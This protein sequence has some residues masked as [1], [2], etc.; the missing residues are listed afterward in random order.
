MVESRESRR[1][2]RRSFIEIPEVSSAALRLH[3][4]PKLD[5][6]VNREDVMFS[7]LSRSIGHVICQVL[8]A[9]SLLCGAVDQRYL[10][11]ICDICLS[12]QMLVMAEFSLLNCKCTSQ[13][14][15]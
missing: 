3:P 8:R 5:I 15:I 9:V 2:R 6:Y 13:I 4:F 11:R 7:L 1:L 10:A 12:Y 14:C